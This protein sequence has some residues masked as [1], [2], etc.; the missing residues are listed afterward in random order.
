M[1]IDY[2]ELKKGGF[3]KQRQKDNFIAR[4][5]SL[6]GNLTSEQLRQLADLADKYGKGYVH[7]TTRQGAEIPWV[8]INDYNNMKSEIKA[9]GLNTGT[10]GPRIRTVVACPGRE[11][12]QFGL[13]NSRETAIELDRAFFG[14]EV[15]IKTKIAVSGCPNSCAKPQENDIG[16]AGAVEPV[17]CAE[18]CVGCGLCQ[19]VCPNQAITM[20]D[21][22]PKIDKSKCLREGSCISSCPTDAWQENRRGYLLYAGGKIGRKPR[23]GQVVAEFIPENEVTEG[24]EKVLKAFAVLGQQGERI[25]DTIARVGVRAFRDEMAWTSIESEL[26]DGPA[27]SNTG[28]GTAG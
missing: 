21:G 4:F 28:S 8:G 2:N 20:A 5:R 11:I 16:L 3:L 24:V 25:A 7:V 19:R 22:K 23:L 10:S 1:T 26:C 9:L 18:K 12:C 27:K 17:L 15:S 6:A 13:M 14:R